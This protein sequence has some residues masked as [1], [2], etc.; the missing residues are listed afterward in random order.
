MRTIV[1]PFLALILAASFVAILPLRAPASMEAPRSFSDF[2]AAE[3]T[4]II[5]IASDSGPNAWDAA[6]RESEELFL[7]LALSTEPAREADSWRLAART[8]LLTRFIAAAP[9]G[10]RERV[11]SLLL[12]NP[13]LADNLVDIINDQDDRAAAASVLL[14][15]HDAHGD[16]VARFPALAAAICAVRDGPVV[17]RVNENTK[18][19]PTPEAIFEHFIRHERRLS[20]DIRRGPP[21]LLAFLADAAP[22]PEE[23]AWAVARHAGNRQVGVLFNFISYDVDHYLHGAE[24]RVTVE[25]FTLPNIQRYGG[26]CVDQGYYAAMVGK[27]IGVPAVMVTGVGRSGEGHLWV[28][29]LRARGRSF[30]WDMTEGRYAESQYHTGAVRDPRTGRVVSEAAI[31]VTEQ[32]FS[33]RRGEIRLAR[34]IVEAAALVARAPGGASGG[35]EPP[36]APIELAPR[37]GRRD[38]PDAGP[39]PQRFIRDVGADSAET[40]LRQAHRACAAIPELWRAVE[41]LGAETELSV[42]QLNHWVDAAARLAGDRWPEF[43]FDITRSLLETMRDDALAARAWDRVHQ[44]YRNRPDL[45]V[46]ARVELA[47]RALKAGD[48]DAAYRSYEDAVRSFTGDGNYVLEAL[49]AAERLLRERRRIDLHLDLLS[50][51]WRRAQRPTNATMLYEQSVWVQL[52][53]RYAS[54]LT[55]AGRANEAKAILRQIDSGRPQAAR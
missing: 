42:S 31:G 6:R 19:A 4:R 46:R 44:R 28:G 3:T 37:P 10:S 25:G 5:T 7:R 16:A 34:A 54:A 53:R 13:D 41:R 1:H 48:A 23:L 33:A 8:L 50:H 12:D 32:L 51:A 27:A 29:Y 40:L 17:F 45:A 24:K 49:D 11:A 38:S 55:S 30:Q 26:V 22:D 18:Q 35:A 2:V 47:E 52:G 39:E 21:E 15:L 20:A 36:G 9:A 14:A 43:T